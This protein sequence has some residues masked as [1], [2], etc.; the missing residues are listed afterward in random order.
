MGAGAG[1]VPGVAG[2]EVGAGVL[3]PDDDA[4]AEALVGADGAE[5]FFVVEGLAVAAGVL[6]P[7]GPDSA[8]DAGGG[9]GWAGGES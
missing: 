1:E 5:A 9:L 6:C 8:D 4:L 3:V 7:E 2:V